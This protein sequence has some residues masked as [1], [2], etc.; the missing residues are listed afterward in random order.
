MTLLHKSFVRA[1]MILAAIMLIVGLTSHPVQ[2][3]EKV[4]F[5]EDI[6]PIIQVRCL[7]CH[8]PQG[9]GYE[10]SGLDLRTYQGLMKGTKYGPM[11]IPGDAFVSNLMVLIDG[12]AKGGVRMPHGKRKLT[13]CDKDLFRW[14]INQG[15]LDN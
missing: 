14:W 3:I 7:S 9:E 13:S 8:Q 12:R 6:S 4:S 5:S 10:E 15:A 2:A 1:P 11:V